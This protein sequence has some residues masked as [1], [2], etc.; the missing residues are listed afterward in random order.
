MIKNLKFNNVEDG[1]KQVNKL[2]LQR[3]FRI[4]LIHAYIE[5]EPLRSEM[6][7]LRISL[8][9]ASKK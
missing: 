9:C 7:D 5:F 1:I 2:Y 6:A 3:G 4:T 8:N